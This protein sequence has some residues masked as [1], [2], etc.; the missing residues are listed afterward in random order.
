MDGVHDMGGMHG[1]GPV[2]RPGG[3]DTHTED[4]EIRAQV[5]SM[6]SN[7][8]SR[9]LIEAIDPAEYLATDYY[10]RWLIAAER[11][12]RGR[13]V[14]EEDLRRW[15][16]VFETDP[17]AEPPTATDTARVDSLR[18]YLARPFPVPEATDPWYAV[19]DRVRVTRDRIEAHHRCPRYVK[20]VEG[21]VER[22][23]GDD[24]PAGSGPD[25]GAA[26]EAFYTVRFSS[27][28]LW[29]ERADEPE[30]ALYIDLWQSHLEPA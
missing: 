30:F 29:G 7:R 16:A 24:W 8:S 23:C 10:G 4:W 17:S 22:V 14:D 3:E 21:T 6:L 19:G 28:D 9:A 25:E 20:G 13:G 11:G 27:L 15:R 12:A 5:L 26:V 2:V 18:S 1:F